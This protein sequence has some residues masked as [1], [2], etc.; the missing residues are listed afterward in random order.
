MPA[1]PTITTRTSSTCAW[2]RTSERRMTGQA[3]RGR[4]RG[5]PGRLATLSTALGAALVT[6]FVAP[7]D[8]FQNAELSLLDTRFRFRG[9]LPPR[10]DVVIVAVDQTSESDFDHPFPWDRRLHARLVDNLARAGARF[11]VFD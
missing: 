8:V 7:L 5:G 10:D 4:R 6:T 9:P 2:C 1:P 11:I 3:G